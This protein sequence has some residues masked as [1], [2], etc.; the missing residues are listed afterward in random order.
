MAQVSTMV[1]SSTKAP[2]F[3]NEGISTTFLPMKAPWRTTQPGTARNPAAENW[4]EPQSPHLL[5]TLSH[6]GPGA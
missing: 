6:Q 1:P 3:T 2:M 4:S 5:A